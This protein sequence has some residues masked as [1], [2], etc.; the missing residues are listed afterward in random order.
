MRTGFSILAG[1]LDHLGELRIALAAATDIAGVDAVLRERFRALGMFAQQLVT[2]EVEVADDRDVDA[3]LREPVANRRDG[4]GGFGRV[5][6]D[7]HQL[8]TG[9][10]QGLDLLDRSL[11]VR[12]VGVRHRL[13]DDGEGAAHPDGANLDGN[14]LLRRAMGHGSL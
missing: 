10:C 2:V 4:G 1:D 7:S 8:R 11:D 5:D 6:G 14:G 12:R 3:L 13:D 9:A